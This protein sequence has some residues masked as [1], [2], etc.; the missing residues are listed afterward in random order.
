VH[1]WTRLPVTTLDIDS[2]ADRQICSLVQLLTV[3][4][5]LTGP[6]EAPFAGTHVGS[7][8]SNDFHCNKIFKLLSELPGGP[9]LSTA[10]SED[11]NHHRSVDSGP[12]GLFFGKGL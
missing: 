12:R 4:G 1:P 9:F 7:G 5:G 3:R 10:E 2:S 6:E 11:I 8:E